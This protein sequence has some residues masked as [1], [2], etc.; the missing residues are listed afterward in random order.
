MLLALFDIDGTLISTRGAGMRAFYR[1][2]DSIFHVQARDGVIRP[3]GKTDPL[4]LKELLAYFG[5]EGRYC[6]ET[7]DA[8]FSAY[9]SYLDDEM[10]RA[11]E[12]GLIRILPGAK[13]LLEILTVEPDFRIGL[14]TGNL[15][16]GAFIKLQNAG[17][18]GYFRF[19]GYG[20]DSENRTDLTRTG[21]QRGARLI[22]P[23]PLEGA[24]VIGDTPLDIHHGRAAGAGTIAVASAKYSMEELASH[25]PDLLV[26][27]LTEA[28][29]IIE[30]MRSRRPM[31]SLNAGAS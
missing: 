28:P 9:L 7:R 25:R 5:L 21:I 4:I 13:E 31:H 29:G 3:D 6:D 10:T 16:K 27:D 12:N 11:K 8:L 20:S 30:F 1:A 26:P 17:L 23:S 2:L 22:A 14:V 19:G 24:F 18:D 15:E